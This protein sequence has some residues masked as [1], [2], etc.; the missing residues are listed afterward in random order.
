MKYTRAELNVFKRQ[1]KTYNVHISRKWLKHDPLLNTFPQNG[2]F[3]CIWILRYRAR[4][5]GVVLFL[6]LYLFAVKQ[7]RVDQQVLKYSAA[8]NAHPSQLTMSGK[9]TLPANLN[10]YAF[11]FVVNSKSLV[12]I[13]ILLGNQFLFC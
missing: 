6:E 8:I 10:D 11:N 5:L 13:I 12:T 3:Y 4:F 2:I 9:W 1:L 7:K